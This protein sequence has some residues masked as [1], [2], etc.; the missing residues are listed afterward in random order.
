MQD[1]IFCKIV[2]KD[3]PS[4]IV[5]E[6]DLVVAFNDV[7]PQAPIHVLVIP[8]KHLTNLAD[9]EVEDKALLGHIHWVAA[10]V[11]RDKGI[12]ETG[13]RVVSNH[14]SD[15]GQVVF[16]LHF[17]VIGGQTLGTFW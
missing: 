2:N 10:Q 17:H 14:N 12:S 4:Q 6:D 13:Y 11:A 7:N 3:I 1:C 15:A 9:M 8:K 5:Y 16:H